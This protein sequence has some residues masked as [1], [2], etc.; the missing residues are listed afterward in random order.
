MSTYGPTPAT[1]PL[2]AWFIAVS[3]VACS[4]AAEEKPAVPRIAGPWW[5]I[6][7]NPD[8]GPLT[9]DE[10]EPV[11]FGIWRAGDG[12]WQLWSCIRKTK[13]EGHTRLFF[14]WEGDELTETDWKPLGIVMRGDPDHGEHPGGLQAPYVVRHDGLWHMFYG[15]WESICLAT[16]KDGKNFRRASISGAG[17]QLFSEGEGNKTRDPM[18]L[19]VGDTWHC[20]YCAMPGQGGIFVRRSKSLS[21]WSKS[22]PQKV[23]AGGAPGQKWWNAECP[24]VVHHEGYFYLFRTSNYKSKP[25]TTVY[26]SRDPLD[27][28]VDDDTKIVAALP[29]AAP[30]I[31]FHRGKYHLAA[32]KPQLDGIRIAALEFRA[33]ERDGK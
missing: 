12:T 14:G 28:G 7:G 15:D 32:L 17:P 4:A 29:V 6:A 33:A 21:D 1:H 2:A 26:R 8:L 27:F 22:K 31:I 13:E 10:Q 25:R 23:C 9:S 18:L 19:K 24:H 30:E 16:S 20:Y 3:C 11:D 5:S